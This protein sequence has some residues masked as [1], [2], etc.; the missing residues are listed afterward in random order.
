MGISIRAYAR[1][2]N[3]SPSTVHKAIKTGRITPEADNTLDPAKADQQWEQNTTPTK[4]LIDANEAVSLNEIEKILAGECA[5]LDK[6]TFTH[7]KIAN[8]ILNVQLK[9]LKLRKEKNEL[10]DKAKTLAEVSSL[11]RATR[12]A[13][14]NWPARISAQMASELKVSPDELFHVLESYVR[15]Y[16]HEI[17][18]KK[19]KLN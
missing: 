2:R 11:A 7:A 10:I 15:D 18:N 6:K 9:N 4:Q 8:E 19:L 12:D 16:L 17:A 13:W 14:L 1:H 5:T 3:V